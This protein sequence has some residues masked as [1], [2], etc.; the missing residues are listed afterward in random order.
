MKTQLILFIFLSLGVFLNGCTRK[1]LPPL[2]NDSSSIDDNIELT[3]SV[4][5]QIGVTNNGIDELEI[6]NSRLFIGGDFF[7][8]NGYTCRSSIDYYSSTGAFDGHTS[9]SFVFGGFYDFYESTSGNLFGAGSVQE[10]FGVRR[11]C[12]WTGSGWTSIIDPGGTGYIVQESP[13]SGKILFGGNFASY[14]YI[15]ECNESSPYGAVPFG[16]GFNSVVYDLEYYNGEL[17]AAGGFTLTGA[18][19]VNY[20]AKWNGTGWEAVGSNN[21]DATVYDLEVF[22]GD[23]YLAGSFDG[24]G[25]L[26]NSNH[27]AKWDGT[28]FSGLGS[29][30]SHSSSIS[31]NVRALKAKGEI[32]YVG[33]TFE[34][35]GGIS[36]DNIAYWNGATWGELGTGITQNV[37][38]IEVYNEKLYVGTQYDFSTLDAY[39]YRW[40]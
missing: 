28:V 16:L 24:I 39:L 4:W 18:T 27:V 5:S 37:K 8:F 17:Y 10:S 40:D 20:L 21:I 15:F 11:V 32:L 30:V 6:Y 22:D 12:K 23:L 19:S 7:N 33:G 26:P 14:N 31:L 3:G 13:N 2:L 25:G 36:T 38:V 1:E 34:S 29:G 35:A 9:N